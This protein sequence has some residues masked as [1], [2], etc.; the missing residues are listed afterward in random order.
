MRNSVHLTALTIA[1]QLLANL[2]VIAAFASATFLVIFA[3]VNLSAFRLRSAIGI[4]AAAPALGV[5]LSTV[6]LIVLLW[7]LWQSSR[8]SLAWLC[9]VYFVAIALEL[10]LNKTRGMRRHQRVLS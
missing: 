1:F 4:N 7:Q 9:A 6:S 2:A 5:T 3:L 8:T 10:T